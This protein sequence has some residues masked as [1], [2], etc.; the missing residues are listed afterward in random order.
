MSVQQENKADVGYH[1]NYLEQEANWASN[2][3]FN[4]KGLINIKGKS[5]IGL[6]C[7][8]QSNSPVY[9]GPGGEELWE[10]LEG[11]RGWGKHTDQAHFAPNKRV[12]R[13]YPWYDY[14]ISEKAKEWTLKAGRN[15]I[16]A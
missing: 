11:G 1:R 8:S 2:E 10:F 5:G 7:Q 6:F 15:F 13:L 4:G 12:Q 9:T 14:P 3:V 16:I